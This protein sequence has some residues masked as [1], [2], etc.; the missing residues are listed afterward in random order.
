MSI[1]SMLTKYVAL[2]GC[3]LLVLVAPFILR[4][5]DTSLTSAADGKV[6]VI[7]PHNETIR[8]EFGRAFTQHM[9]AKTGNTIQVDWRT[10]GAGTSE[11]TRFINSEYAGAFENYWKNTQDYEWDSDYLA[12]FNDGK[13]KLP[14]GNEPKT[15]EQKVRELFLNSTVGI[16]VDLF[17]GGGTYDFQ[18]QKKLGYLVASTPDGKAGL[19]AVAEKNPDLFTEAI[20]PQEVSG[21]PYYDPELCWAGATLSAFG[22][23]YNSDVVTALGIEKP[24]A[25][26][27]DLAEPDYFRNIAMA[28]PNLSGSVTKAFEMLMQQQIQE[29]VDKEESSPGH[30]SLTKEDQTRKKQQAIADGWLEG[31]RMIQDIGANSRYFTD[32]ATKIPHDVAQG[33]A[34]AGMCVDFYGRTYNEK[35]RKDDGSSRV[36]FV[37]PK[38]GTSTG[39]D[40]IGMFRGAPNPGYATEFL[41]FVLSPQGQKLWNYRK[42]EPGGPTRTSLRRLPVRKDL[43]TPEHLKHFSDPDV[44]PYDHANEFVY[45]PKYTAAY[46]DVIRLLVRVMCIDVHPELQQA[47]EALIANRFPKI[48]TATYRDLRLVTFQKSSNRLKEVLGSGDKLLRLRLTRDLAEHFRKQ[49]H[50][51]TEMANRGE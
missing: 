14:D 37:V 43:Y 21:E 8:R 7:T 44:L 25:T 17:F 15:T 48:A 18:K 24:P 32:T 2:I 35:L 13:I 30:A 27:A 38:A 49:Y 51:V 22:I 29:A 3:M 5:T 16:G 39:V 12:Y 28:D 19:A 9:K 47:R 33:E 11:I 1:S 10:P 23:C 40:P 26:W 41:D 34:A 31:L 36:H 6:V 4:P 45:V 42:G 20:F 50:K 46:F